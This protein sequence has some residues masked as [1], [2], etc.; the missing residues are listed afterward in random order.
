[1]VGFDDDGV[2]LYR[3]DIALP[4][5]L[6]CAEYDGIDF[7]SD[8]TDVQGDLTRRNW[9]TDHR[10]WLI[11][12]FRQESVYGRMPDATSRLA[13]AYAQVRSGSWN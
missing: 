3:L 11:E 2:P 1:M 4:D 5:L 9:L 7:P 10:S 8:P 13:S 12:V 6:F